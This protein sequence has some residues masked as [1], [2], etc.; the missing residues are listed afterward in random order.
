MAEHIQGP[1]HFET[2]GRTGPVMAFIHPNPMDHSSWVYQLAHFST[3]FRCIAI[4]LPG[5]GRSPTAT[6]GLT[7]EDVA[8][9][10][11][12]A[13]DEAFP[14]EAAVLVGSSIGAAISLYMH[15]A[16]PQR[17][18]ALAISGMGFNPSKAF[19]AK[20]IAGFAER[21]L[22]Y[23]W[24]YTL[25]SFS[26]AF[27]STPLAQYFAQLFT[28]RN[29]GADVPTIIRQFEALAMPDPDGHH[30]RIACPTIILT[31][32][33]DDA[34]RNTFELQRRIPDCELEIL[35]GAG[36]AC[37]MEQPW[38]FDRLLIEFLERKGLFPAG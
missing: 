4:D 29:S 18:R 20:R 31:G 19:V 22:E 16:E 12:E 28:D 2:T 30:A 3:W 27:R 38:L 34:H 17:T 7:M 23:G 11:W 8:A 33:E 10:C 15:H 13:I 9:G 5:Y 37:H 21:G 26:P 24:P 14:G 1:L 35:P 36:H 6:P 25:E 32:T